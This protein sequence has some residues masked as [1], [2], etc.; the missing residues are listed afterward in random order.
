MN[1]LLDTL[2]YPPFAQN[3]PAKV[4]GKIVGLVVA[5]LSAIGL[6]FGLGGIVAVLG[7][8]AVAAAAGVSYIVPLALLG[9]LVALVAYV[10][11][12][13]GGWQMYQ[14]KTQGKRLVVAGLALSFLGQLVYGIGSTLGNVIVA[15]IILAAIYYVVVISRLPGEQTV[16]PRSS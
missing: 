5:I 3:P 12:L 13:M 6:L 14:G 8:G 16:T 7:V 9:L 2:T 4:D 1:S 10:L 11:S 15:L